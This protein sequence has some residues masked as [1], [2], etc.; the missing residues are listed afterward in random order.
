MEWLKK[1]YKKAL[2]KFKNNIF[3]KTKKIRFVINKKEK[4]QL[5]KGKKK[6]N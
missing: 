1:E 4:S 6:I 5:L 3:N 2:K